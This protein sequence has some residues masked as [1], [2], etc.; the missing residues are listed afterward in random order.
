MH[1]EG[2][3]CRSVVLKSFGGVDQLSYLT[4]SVDTPEQ[5]LLEENCVLG[6]T[7]III[8]VRACAISDIDIHVREGQYKFLSPKE[9][10]IGYEIAGVCAQH[11]KLNIAGCRKSRRRY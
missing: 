6:G 5:I 8:N 11:I 9:P 10:I 1:S 3:I 4:R 7:Q 2:L